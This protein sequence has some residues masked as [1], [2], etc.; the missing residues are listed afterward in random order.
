M[1]GPLTFNL[2]NGTSLVTVTLT[3]A[4]GGGVTVS[5][6]ATGKADIRGIAFDV[7]DNRLPSNITG[8]DV[9][10]SLSSASAD[11]ITR[12]GN[13]NFSGNPYDVG[14]LFNSGGGSSL[15]RTTSFTLTGISLAQLSSQRFTAQVTGVSGSPSFFGTAPLI[16]APPTAVVSIAFQGN[17]PGL[18]ENLIF[19]LTGDGK[20]DSIFQP[21][22]GGSFF[23]VIKVTNTS[24]TSTLSNARVSVDARSALFDTD[25]STLAGNA[26][27]TLLDDGDGNAETALIEIASIAP[28]TFVELKVAT[29]L[30]AS[31][32]IATRNLT[33]NTQAGSSPNDPGASFNELKLY[34]NKDAYSFNSNGDFRFGS[35]GSYEPTAQLISGNSSSAT[36]L[37]L[38]LY[39]TSFT[40]NDGVHKLFSVSDHLFNSDTLWGV[41][42]TRS[43][44]PANF[45]LLLLWASDDPVPTSADAALAYIDGGTFDLANSTP[46]FKNFSAFFNVSGP[47]GFSQTA[48]AGN[49][50]DSDL[51]EVTFS[52]G[53]FQNFVNG[54]DSTKQYRILVSGTSTLNWSNYTA[55]YVSE[56][57]FLNASG[58]T[59]TLDNRTSVD[60]LNLSGVRFLYNVSPV[61]RVFVPLKTLTITGDGQNNNRTDTVIGSPGND[62]ILGSNGT[63]YLSGGQGDDIINGG[64]GRDFIDGG[65]G[66]DILTGGQGQDEFIF[67][68]R[69]GSDII[70]DFTGNQ[71]T[72][73]FR[74]FGLNP[75]QFASTVTINRTTNTTTID[76]TSFGGGDIT[77]QAYAPNNAS[78]IP[79]LL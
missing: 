56:V 66:N 64:N 31:A 17:T 45:D 48:L 68:G 27:F 69:F 76:L 11:S 22:L 58:G 77:L 25:F 15:V 20:N 19:D 63:D 57:V 70:T 33:F 13:I 40:A 42:G 28:G 18:L 43:S 32:N 72:L 26:A 51:V 61:S 9:N 39:G 46:T 24:A 16:A 5:L 29:Q 12:V 41:K 74:S 8:T 54:L 35:F 78:A 59:A 1:A 37:P 47:Q 53:N 10:T 4:I 23:K 6:S 3:E 38:T 34:L 2:S 75:A 49:F 52:G 30:A 36:L 62:I 67:S 60:T 14:V 73:N 79:V 21:E 55:S 50:S 44:S 65:S 7:V 71:D